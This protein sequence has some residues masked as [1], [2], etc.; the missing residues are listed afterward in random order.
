MSKDWIRD[1][2]NIKEPTISKNDLERSRCRALLVDHSVIDFLKSI[3]K[4]EQV[5]KTSN[6]WKD[7][8]RIMSSAYMKSTE[9]RETLNKSETKILKSKDSRMEPWET[10]DRT[11]WID[12]KRGKGLYTRT[13]YT[14]YYMRFVRNEQINEGA[15]KTSIYL[16]VHHG[17][18][19]RK[20]LWS[21]AQWWK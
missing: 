16:K 9:D 21:P 10:S 19:Y 14:R 1:M 3:F 8:K 6:G 5:A 7:L 13:C 4:V 2:N 15:G 12:G 11:A 18:R 20:P 17:W